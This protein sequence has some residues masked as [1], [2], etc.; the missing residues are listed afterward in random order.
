MN[1]QDAAARLND[2]N[3]EDII[4]K[5][6]PLEREIDRL[7]H[8]IRLLEEQKATL[9]RR[10]FFDGLGWNELCAEMRLSPKT[11]R[12]LRE[13]AIDDLAEMYEFAGVLP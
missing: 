1:Y 5:L 10:H 6:I 8:Y 3:R 7:E 11:L 12:K 4:G 9:L 13:E 2:E